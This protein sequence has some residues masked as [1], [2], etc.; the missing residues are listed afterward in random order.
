MKLGDIKQV[1]HC[2]GEHEVN[3]ALNAGFKIFKIAQKRFKTPE[4]EE[5]AIQYCMGK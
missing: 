4:T 3:A 2:V 5:V 1:K